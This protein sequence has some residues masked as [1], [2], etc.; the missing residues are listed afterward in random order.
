MAQDFYAASLKILENNLPGNL[1]KKERLQPENPLSPYSFMQN[2]LE[3]WAHWHN[4][5]TALPWEYERRAWA[6]AFWTALYYINM[7]SLEAYKSTTG[8]WVANDIKEYLGR[9]FQ[10]TRDS[11]W[12]NRDIYNFYGTASNFGAPESVLSLIRAI[13]GLS[14]TVDLLDNGGIKFDD[15]S[16]ITDWNRWRLGVASLMKQT[17]TTVHKEVKQIRQQKLD[18][19]LRHKL[20][21]QHKAHEQ[22]MKHQNYPHTNYD[23]YGGPDIDWDKVAESLGRAEHKEQDDKHRQI[24]QGPETAPDDPQGLTWP[25]HRYTGPGN[26][27]PAGRPVDPIDESAMDH[28]IRYE[29]VMRHH[30]WP[31]LYDESDDILISDIKK[32]GMDHTFLGNLISAIM[33]LKKKVGQPVRD[34]FRSV[35]PLAPIDIIPFPE[36]DRQKAPETSPHRPDSSSQNS[37]KTSSD[38]HQQPDTTDVLPTPPAKKPNM[39]QQQQ[40]HVQ[41]TG[42][43]HGMDSNMASADAPTVASG[44]G[45]G[46]KPECGKKWWGGTKWEGDTVTTFS[47]RRCNLK[48]YPDNYYAHRSQ[49]MQPGV[50][51]IT[52]WYYFDLNSMSSH[53]SPASFQTLIETQDKIRPKSLSIKLHTLLFK[54]VTTNTEGTQSIQDISSGILL[55]HKDTDYYLPYPMGG[56]QLTHPGHMP[57]AFYQLPR[58]SY[59]T[60]GKLA[61]NFQTSGSYTDIPYVI[62]QDTELFLIED[63]LSDMLFTG[64]CYDYHYDFPALPWAQLTQYPWNP[65]RQDNPLAEQKFLVMTNITDADIF[66]P[67]G[68]SKLVPLPF[69]AKQRP[70]QWLPAPKYKQGDYSQITPQEKKDAIH[71]YKRQMKSDTAIRLARETDT[72]VISNTNW[73]TLQP[74]PDTMSNVVRRPEGNIVIT[75][76]AMGILLR[77]EEHQYWNHSANNTQALNTVKLP[78]HNQRGHNGPDDPMPILQQNIKDNSSTEVTYGRFPGSVWERK[79]LHYESQI[80]TKIPNTDFVDMP[81]DNPLAQWAMKNPPHLLLIRQIQTLGPPQENPDSGAIPSNT[82]LNQYCQFLISYKI[83][84]EVQQRQ[85]YTPRWNPVPPPQLPVRN[86]KRPIYVMDLDTY[87]QGVSKTGSVYL[88]PDEVWTCKQRTRDR[89]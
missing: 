46:G 40:Q 49:D 50:N 33:T 85:R 58:Y 48:P 13:L 44:G 61:E 52:P 65:R 3:K 59:R 9:L 8:A 70:A 72:M 35:W 21:E 22:Y 11:G 18:E 67:H 36:Q 71:W 86:D 41:Q 6:Y 14:N 37:S 5:S 80:W 28:D 34:A 60:F 81:Q 23:K 42:G 62:T 47:T 25:G 66:A 56:G 27:V 74:G 38:K 16:D 29:Q 54:D 76:N 63:Q 83:T 12:T 26:L 78:I 19:I 15:T 69:S 53:W 55:V 45:G 4:W 84:W 64:D 10:G 24:L 7:Q 43:H 82:V 17:L 57:G 32:H 88:T 75:S 73:E 20:Q 31:Y 79:A 2:R 68:G 39:S 89:R 51:I 30:E 1:I 77:D 87:T